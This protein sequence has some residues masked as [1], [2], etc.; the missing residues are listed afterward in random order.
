MDLGIIIVIVL[1]I[2]YFVRWEDP[3][4]DWTA[5][6]REAV[7]HMSKYG[8]PQLL[9]S[10]Y[11]VWIDTAICSRCVLYGDGRTQFRIPL[12]LFYGTDFEAVRIPRSCE[13]RKLAG[14][15]EM[16]GAGMI[17][18]DSVQIL[19]DDLGAAI[20]R[21]GRIVAY[22]ADTAS[23]LFNDDIAT[24]EKLLLEFMAEKSGVCQ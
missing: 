13:E 18:E 21:A 24:R 19:A 20:D 23:S 16:L 3:L 15:R 5:A 10:R 4:A 11:A 9:T 17:G 14:L 6:A 12:D 7:R 22:C 8:A 2:V 1:V